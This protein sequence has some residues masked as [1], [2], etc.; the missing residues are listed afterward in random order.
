MKKYYGIIS[1]ICIIVLALTMFCGCDDRTE[2]EREECLKTSKKIVAE[3]IN[4]KYP[5][6]DL[7]IINE[8]YIDNSSWKIL[9]S[10]GAWFELSDNHYVMFDEDKYKCYDNV[11]VKEIDKAIKNYI[12]SCLPDNYYLDGDFEFNIM[13]GDTNMNGEYFQT[14]WTGNIEDFL[15]NENLLTYSGE[16]YIPADKNTSSDILNECADKLKE[17][18]AF[19]R[20]KIYTCTK[21]NFLLLKTGVSTNDIDLIEGIEI[22]NDQTTHINCEPETSE[23][24]TTEVKTQ[25][26]TDYTY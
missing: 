1:F 21:N 17:Y 7:T 26:A 22:N 2:E 5:D 8:G 10:N 16:I 19:E 15:K 3:Y 12:I 13:G 24:E 18:S 4:D 23:D 6:K 14:K 11:Q 25:T 20:L 9:R